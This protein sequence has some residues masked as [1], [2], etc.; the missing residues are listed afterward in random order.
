MNIKKLILT[1]LPYL[2]FAYALARIWD[3]SSLDRLGCANFKN[4]SA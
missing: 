1:N 2:L 4:V 3:I